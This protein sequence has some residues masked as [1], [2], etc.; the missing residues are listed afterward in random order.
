MY[1]IRKTITCV[2]RE[3][4]G[5]FEITGDYN[6]VLEITDQSGEVHYISNKEFNRLLNTQKIKKL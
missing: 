5:T 3:V 6:G 1:K 4:K 2:G